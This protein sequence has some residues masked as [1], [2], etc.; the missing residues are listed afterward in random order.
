M[1][2]LREIVIVWVVWSIALYFAGAFI[3]LDWNPA[4]WTREGR[5]LWAIVD[6]ALPVG[7]AM[8]AYLEPAK[9][10]NYHE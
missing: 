4:N 10:E 8:L 9:K 5:F 3:A 2:K 7:V 1:K 6:L